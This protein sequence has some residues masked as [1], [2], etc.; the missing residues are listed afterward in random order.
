MNKKTAKK[1]NPLE[2]QIQAKDIFIG[3]LI[4]QRKQLEGII[5]DLKKE[6]N[7]KNEIIKGYEILTDEQMGMIKDKLKEDKRS[8]FT[9]T[10]LGAFMAYAIITFVTLNHNLFEWSNLSRLAFLLIIPIF[11]IKK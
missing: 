4:E 5:E 9:K 10:I 1:V 3:E 2:A 6:V 7:K 8:K 11:S